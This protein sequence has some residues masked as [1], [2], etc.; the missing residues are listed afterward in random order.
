M[1]PP[2][3]LIAWTCGLAVA[4]LLP[5]AASAQA[6]FEDKTIGEATALVGQ[7]KGNVVLVHIFASSDPTCRAQLAI[8]NRLSSRYEKHP[9]SNRP[10]PFKFLALSIDED[11]EALGKYLKQDA[12]QGQ[13]IR[14]IAGPDNFLATMKA[15]GMKE[16]KDAIPYTAVFDM[17]GTCV[18]EFTGYTDFRTFYRVIDDIYRTKGG[19]KSAADEK[20]DAAIKPGKFTAVS[21]A[22]LGGPAK[23][24][25]QIDILGGVSLKHIILIAIGVGGALLVAAGIYMAKRQGSAP[26]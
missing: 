25:G 24:D 20:G 22:K 15:A 10:Y 13:A 7:A 2:R 17:G 19:D 23:G 4:G 12:V 8:L 26:R 3:W 21:V 14:L 11:Q 6:P 1:F 16:F 9:V 5:R 18:K